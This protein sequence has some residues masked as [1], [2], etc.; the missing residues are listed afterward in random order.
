M[1]IN[2]ISDFIKELQKIPKKRDFELYFRGHS[3]KNFVLE[4]SIYRSKRIISNEN[5]IFKEFILR[6]PS[7]FLNEKSALEKLVKMQH[8]GLPTRLLDI[9]TNPL[10]ALYF[11]C[12]EKSKQ[13]GKVFA[14]KVPKE[15]IKYYDS[16][17]V[18]I[19][20]NIAKRP[21]S[22]SIEKIRNLKNY[23]FNEQEDLGYLLHEIKEEKSYFQNI[24]NAS[25]IERVVAVK[26]KQNNNRIIKQSGAFLIFGVN[27]T[28]ALPAKIPND[29]I[30]NLELKDVDFE[31]N[32]NSKDDI[33]D[34][35]NLLGINEATLFPEL[36]NQ[37]KY[38][39]KYYG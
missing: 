7:D 25:D 34:E 1:P 18:S 35:L 28:K 33:I 36:E 32:N 2:T 27:G 17:T 4:P 6:T 11:A 21:L 37:A 22:F 24:I 13:D 16:D 39:K 12:N 20:A 14:F 5:K 9:T 8:Y 3:D 19:I 31:I 15:D 29:W 23:E 10:V 30:I 26:V 38:L